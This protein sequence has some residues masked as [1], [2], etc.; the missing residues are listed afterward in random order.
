MAVQDDEREVE[1]REIIGLRKGDGRSG[2]DA[3]MDFAARGLR[4]CVPI[5]LKSTTVGSVSTARDVGRD[6]LEKWRS[7]VWVVGF[8]GSSGAVLESLLVLGPDDMEPWISRIERY[9]APDFMIG[10]RISGK[11]EMEDLHVICGEKDAYVLEDAQALYKRQWRQ[12]M[13]T[14]RMDLPDGYSPNR[15]L[16]ILRLRA[17]YLLDRGSTLNNPRIPRT[18]FA[19]FADRA[20]SVTLG[21]SELRRRIR[22][23]IAQ[24][25]LASAQL[26]RLAAAYA[27]DQQ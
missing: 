2:V 15:M 13:Y 16:E 3:Y 22:R 1:M 17:R 26:S 7:R 27:A 8:Y 24:T 9:M 5:E 18:F 11:L 4:Y 20:A 12:G 14:A 25:A 21:S 19:A 10:E 6:H 23:T